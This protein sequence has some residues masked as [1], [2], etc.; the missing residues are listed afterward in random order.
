MRDEFVLAGC[1]EFGGGQSDGGITETGAF[2]GRRIGVI[3]RVG[4]WASFQEIGDLLITFQG[5]HDVLLVG[6]RVEG[7]S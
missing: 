4:L 7:E 1:A 6:C 2:R 5:R 3:D